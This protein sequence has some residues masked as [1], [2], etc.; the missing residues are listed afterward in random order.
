MGGISVI[1][2]IHLVQGECVE[3]GFFDRFVTHPTVQNSE[4]IVFLGDIF[5]L[6][7]GSYREYLSQYSFFFDYIARIIAEGKHV[8]YVEGNHD[9][10]LESLFEYFF[11]LQGLNCE[12]FFYHKGGFLQNF[13]K[14]NIYFSHGDEMDVSDKYY[15]YYRSFISSSFVRL[16]TETLVSH[17]FIE[18]IGHQASEKSRLRNQH[19]YSDET[20]DTVIREK[21]RCRAQ[22]VWNAI[23]FDLLVCGHTHIKDHYQSDQGFLYINNGYAPRE[24]T[25][26]YI[27]GEMAKFQAV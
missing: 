21:V 9:L 20:L 27:D 2:D 14:R 23:G 11:D 15:P 6:L 10:H 8:H 5:D 18:S 1:S 12:R 26:I 22:R 17:S 19:K 13:S 7:F 16:L 3:K 4:T 24:N 25:F